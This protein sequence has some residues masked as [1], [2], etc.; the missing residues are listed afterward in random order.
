MMQSADSLCT[1]L[2]ELAPVAELGGLRARA[3]ILINFLHD[4][5]AEDWEEKEVKA[6]EA[7]LLA[8]L[9]R[10]VVDREG[11]REAFTSAMTGW[12][13]DT[14]KDF[15]HLPKRVKDIT[16]GLVLK[17]VI[18]ASQLPKKVVDAC[19]PRVNR[20][21]EEEAAK[22]RGEEPPSAMAAPVSASSAAPRVS[23]GPPR[24]SALASLGSFLEEAAKERK[25][26]VE[27][28]TAAKAASGPAV[29]APAA[30]SA[31]SAAASAAPAAGGVGDEAEADGLDDLYAEAS[32][33]KG[34]KGKKVKKKKKGADFALEGEGEEETVAA[35]AV[36][37]VEVQAD[38][39]AELED[40]Y[41]AA[42]KKKAKKAKKKSA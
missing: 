37:V 17:R 41:A 24:I 32:K 25:G 2:A 11:I 34:K 18:R 23:A 13:D 1:S 29:S 20:L 16:Q 28:P 12:F 26:D 6:V 31:E 33:K 5:V 22:D 40:L 30:A 8:L 10:Q 14:I 19:V 3:F 9:E 38:A 35:P 39:A 21:V 42:G 15:P 36:P 4:S 7:G 27:A